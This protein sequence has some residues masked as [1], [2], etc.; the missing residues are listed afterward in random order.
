MAVEVALEILE[1]DDAATR[2]YGGIQ[3]FLKRAGKPVGGL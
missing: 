2:A 3:A 1:F